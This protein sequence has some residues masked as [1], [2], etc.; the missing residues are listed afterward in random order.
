MVYSAKSALHTFLKHAPR[1]KLIR[2]LK[3][4]KLIDVNTL[5]IL[6]RGI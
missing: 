5:E 4:Y 3:Y 1:S 2:S 6:S